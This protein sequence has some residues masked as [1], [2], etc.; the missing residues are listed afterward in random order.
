M[1][2]AAPD[3]VVVREL[4]PK[5]ISENSY[6]RA[7]AALQEGRVNAALADLDKAVEIDPRQ[8]GVPSTKGTLT[9]N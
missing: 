6:R 8:K 9:Q 2:A 1:T 7:L 4:T 3:G 5:Q